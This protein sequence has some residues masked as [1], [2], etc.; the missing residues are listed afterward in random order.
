MSARASDPLDAL[1]ARDLQLFRTIFEQSPASTQ[2]FRP[3]GLTVGVNRA[4]EKLW[5]LTLEELGAYNVLQDEQ[6]VDKGI[7]PYLRRAFAGETV[8]V[9]A[10]KYVPDETIR[11]VTDVQYRWVTALAYPIVNDSGEI[12]AVVLMHEDVTVQHD[13]EL[14]VRAN[15]ALFRSMFQSAPVGIAL[16]DQDSRYVAVNPVRAEMLGYSERDLLGKSYLEVTHPDD[17]A[18]DQSQNAE[19]RSLGLD[20]FGFEK[21]FVRRDGRLHWARVTAA[22]V[23]GAEPTRWISITEDITAQKEAEAER[24]RLLAQVQSALADT[25][26]AQELLTTVVEQLPIGV[27]VTD[28]TG[29]LTL[30]N[31]V[32]RQAAAVPLHVDAPI[33]AQYG[34]SGL[35]DAKDD[36][37]VSPDDT[38]VA[39]ALRGESV[40]NRELIYKHLETGAETWISASGVPIR[41]AAGDVT[42]AVVIFHDVTAVHLL[43]QQKT[44][45]LSAVAHD[46]RTPLT[47]IKGRAQIMERRLSHPQPDVQSLVGDAHRIEVAASRM[48]T[49]VTDLLD[50]ANIELGRP[51]VL[52]RR[53]TDLVALVRTAIDQYAS[54]SEQHTI[55]CETDLSE[56]TGQWDGDRLERVVANLLSNAVKYSPA[57]GEIVVGVHAADA[58]AVIT[59]SDFGI[60]IA[61]ADLQYIFERFQ[62]GANVQPSMAGAGIGLSVVKE[63]VEQHGGAVSAERRASGGTTFTVRLPLGDGPP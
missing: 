14:S 32:A 17:I 39:R 53:E 7:M 9:P 4:W 27:L 40:A 50:V 55:R 42:G 19:A 38:V 43:E 11:G 60:G 28:R 41:S 61:E 47:S 18:L 23:P 30:L 8:E 1:G 56:L 44:E 29:R 63:I 51:V 13:M 26:A 54:V 2:I 46:L 34:A 22:R 37:I 59:V 48:M 25:A 10:V 16:I 57:G 12:A 35:R 58:A 3:D 33:A 15:E 20:H 36:R 21:R 62:R 52:S 5:G 24:E 6:L 49:L 45:F 31:E